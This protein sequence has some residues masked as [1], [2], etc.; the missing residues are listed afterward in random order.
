MSF[1][2]ITSISPVVAGGTVTIDLPVGQTYHQVQLLLTNI[3]AAQ[4]TQIQVIA[5]TKVIQ[6][7]DDFAELDALNDFYARPQAGNYHTIWFD[8][9]ELHESDRELTALGTIGLETVQIKFKVDAAAISPAVSVRAD[10]SIGTPVGLITKIKRAAY[11]FTSSGEVDMS[12]MPKIGKVV[13]LHYKKATD[14]ITTLRIVRDEVDQVETTV[15]D[16]EEWQKQYGRVPVAN[17]V[18]YDFTM[19]GDLD[20]S[21]EVQQYS[22]GMPVQEF[23]SKLTLGTAE[24]VVLLSEHIDSL[25]GS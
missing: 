21:L 10:R 20:H 7:F 24:T 13:G 2:P 3:T 25:S 19:K 1:R 22:D 18:H 15:A 23:Y 8:R 12:K 11:P 6:E 14:D 17:Y 5:G 4:G 16:L 9:P